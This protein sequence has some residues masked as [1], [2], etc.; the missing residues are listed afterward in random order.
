[1]ACLGLTVLPTH[2]TKEPHTLPKSLII[3]FDET[4]NNVG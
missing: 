3:T 2:K 4:G 1:M